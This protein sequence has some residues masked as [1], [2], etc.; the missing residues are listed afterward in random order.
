MGC[1]ER[2]MDFNYCRKVRC[3]YTHHNA[4][5]IVL[6]QA[7]ESPKKWEG[8]ATKGHSP[9]WAVYNARTVRF[10]IF[11]YFEKVTNGLMH[12]TWVQVQIIASFSVKKGTLPMKKR[13]NFSSFTPSVWDVIINSK[14]QR[15]RLAENSKW[16]RRRINGRRITV[17]ES[18]P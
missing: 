4:C 11:M 13:A 3:T 9:Q 8:T 12:L 6:G 18:R 5:A 14:W 17:A 1:I 2:Q 10:P 16:W 15:S 7:A